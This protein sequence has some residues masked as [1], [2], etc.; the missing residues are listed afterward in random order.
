MTPGP[1]FSARRAP[2]A[3]PLSAEP[4]T[5]QSGG[6]APHPRELI[7]LIPLFAFDLLLGTWL[8]LHAKW[9]LQWLTGNVV[10]FG[11]FYFVW[12][13][14]PDETVKHGRI[15]FANQLRSRTLT[16]TLWAIV[17]AFLAF[18]A[19]VSTIHVSAS[20]LPAPVTVYRVDASPSFPEGAAPTDSVRLDKDHG[21]RTFP[22]LIAPTGRPVWLHTSSHLRSAT[23]RAIPWVPRYLTYPTDF[24]ML[25]TAAAL[26]M[27]NLMFDIRTSQPLRLV[28]RSAD[29]AARV[30][31]DDTLRAIQALL[32]SFTKPAAPDSATRSQWLRRASVVLD[33]DTSE[34]VPLVD[35]WMQY[36]WIKT[37]RPLRGGE[38]LDVIVVAP[39]GD[40]LVA[41]TVTLTLPFS[42]VFLR[43][44]T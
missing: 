38:R 24:D 15:S 28:V 23:I 40:T 42:N 39:A 25:A 35:K 21:T 41:D 22:V 2:L 44:R 43:R 11:L 26:P 1:S 30:V 7:A 20:N 19:F 36:R 4:P 29:A 9:L 31:A 18:T 6:S 10:L 13:L 32:F 3:A 16:W 12:K 37:R 34:V 14:L 33:V 5:T 8:A 27:G 17:G